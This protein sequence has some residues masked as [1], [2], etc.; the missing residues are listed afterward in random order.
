[1]NNYWL[2]AHFIAI[3]GRHMLVPETKRKEV[4]P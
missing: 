1:M 4:F 3:C 2:I